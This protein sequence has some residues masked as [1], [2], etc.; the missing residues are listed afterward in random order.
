M[1]TTGMNLH[2]TISNVAIKR[3][4]EEAAASVEIEQRDSDG[5]LTSNTHNFRL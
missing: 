1:C 5:Q 3:E 2:A 4:E